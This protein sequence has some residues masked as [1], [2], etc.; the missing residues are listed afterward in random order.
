METNR[1]GAAWLAARHWIGKDLLFAVAFTA[2]Q[3]GVVVRVHHQPFTTG[4]ISYAVTFGVTAVVFFL[5]Q[6]AWTAFVH[7]WKVNF[8]KLDDHLQH[9]LDTTANEPKMGPRQHE[10]AIDTQNKINL[11]TTHQ[12]IMTDV[13]AAVLG[14]TSKAQHA[15]EHVEKCEKTVM[16]T[17]G[18]VD[19][20]SLIAF[21]TT[22]PAP[23]P[24]SMAPYYVPRWR[25]VD[26]HV[27]WLAM[28]I[29]QLGN[30][31][32]EDSR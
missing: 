15:Q 21:E 10:D 9:H 28:R 24:D 20:A 13:L 26:G 1:W 4:L 29:E 23:A 17:F 16:D 12:L 19:L 11:L 25:Q 7:P 8:R 27:R 5:L 3:V 31:H 18:N 2:L 6:F 14:D 30:V 22:N 32:Q